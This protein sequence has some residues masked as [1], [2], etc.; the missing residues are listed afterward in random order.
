MLSTVERVIFLQGIDVFAHV[1]SEDL[2]HIAAITDEVEVEEGQVIYRE[3]EIADCMYVVIQGEFRVE[4]DGV[5][6]MIARK[7][8]AVGTWSL[9]DD[10][11][12]IATATAITSGELLKI[13]KE[14]FVDLLSDHVKITQGIMKTI[15]KR[16][17]SLMSNINRPA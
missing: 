4:R 3:S 17:R 7:H 10:E 14:D 12:R 11:R 5:E 16:L 1:S 8:D 6:V 15:V 9:F 13:D 2:V